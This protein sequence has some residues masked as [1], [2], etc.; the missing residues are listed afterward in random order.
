[1]RSIR[2][3]TIV[4]LAAMLT[5]A[6]GCA[7]AMGWWAEMWTPDSNDPPLYS[8]PKHKTILVMPDDY[9]SRLQFD[10]TRGALSNELNKLLMENNVT[11]STI[12]FNKLQEAEGTQGFGKL[13]VDQVG[14]QVGADVVINVLFDRMSL[15]DDNQSDLWHGQLAL[16]VKVVDAKTGLRLW[17]KDRVDGWPIETVDIAPSSTAADYGP[18]LTQELVVEAAKR[19][20]YLF[21]DHPSPQRLIKQTQ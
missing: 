6:G 21:C 18:I 10:S 3:I 11:G 14:R 4:L 15:R 16:R 8:I 19:I 17:P 1:M 9:Y 5:C 12:P 20:A 7:D 13:T 2:F